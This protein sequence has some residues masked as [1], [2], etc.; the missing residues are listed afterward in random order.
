MVTV[1]VNDV[2]Q[3]HLVVIFQ[4]VVPYNLPIVVNSLQVLFCEFLAISP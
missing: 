3:K 4:L 1:N 2:A